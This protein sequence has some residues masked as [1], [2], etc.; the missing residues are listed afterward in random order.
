MLNALPGAVAD[1]VLQ[2]PTIPTTFCVKQVTH[3]Y[4]GSQGLAIM[5]AS[6]WKR[7]SATN[8][9]TSAASGASTGAV[10]PST[11]PGDSGAAWREWC[12]WG[13]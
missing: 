4:A 1:T 11:S 10:Q 3:R 6:R 7:P 12:T 5:I 9:N 13:K 2:A 8:T